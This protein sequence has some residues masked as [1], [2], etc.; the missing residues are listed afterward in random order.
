MYVADFDFVFS[1]EFAACCG[2]GVYDSLIC[3]DGCIWW[4]GEL[5][6]LYLIT[7]FFV[8]GVVWHCLISIILVTLVCYLGWVSVVYCS[9]LVLLRVVGC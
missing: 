8:L 7:G 3:F 4:V 5:V 9:M 6:T 2:D 1:D